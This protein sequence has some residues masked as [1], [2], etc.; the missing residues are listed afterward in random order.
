MGD[1]VIIMKNAKGDDGMQQTGS[2]QQTIKEKNRALVLRAVLNGG[3]RSRAEIARS[4]GLTK[5]TL[6]NI[7]SGLIEAKIL[8]ESEPLPTETGGRKSI[9][10]SLSPEAPL[11]CGVLVQ[12]G[13]LRVILS[14][15]CG[16]IQT[17]CAYRFHGLIAPDFFQKK[18]AALCR[19]C[20]AKAEKPVLAGGISCAGPVNTTEGT[21]VNP[22]NFFTEPFSFPICR[23]VEEQTGLRCFLSNDA[24]AGAIAEKLFGKGREEE[25]FVYI[26]TYNGI[27]AGFYLENRIYNGET[28]QSGELGHM[29][30]N[31]DGA[32]CACG[33]NGCLELYASIPAILEKFSNLRQRLPEHPL[34]RNE[35]LSLPETVALADEGDVLAMT[36]VTEYCRYLAVACTNLITQLDIRMLILSGSSRPEGHFF[37]ETLARLVNEKVLIFSSQPCRAVQSGFGADSPL[38]GSVGMLLDRIFRGELSPLPQKHQLF[39]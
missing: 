15:L 5:T 1:Y 13:C 4:L 10:L 8:T 28:G 33:N 2:R 11:L 19:E 7:V 14:N 6:T 20:L 16:E 3:L 9:G 30:I 36:V 17:D 23:F 38:Y 22:H 21:L 25:N 34:F 24:T 37:P 35:P 12:R 29:S 32:K 18:L 27:G 31:F 39:R 26:S